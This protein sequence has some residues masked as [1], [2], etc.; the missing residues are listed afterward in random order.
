VV[1]LDH[2]IAIDYFPKDEPIERKMARA[3]Q[4]Y[5]LL[6]TSPDE[7]NQKLI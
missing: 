5:R 7:K 3:M 2:K 4:S 6:K 1:P